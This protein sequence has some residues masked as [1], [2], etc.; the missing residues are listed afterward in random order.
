MAGEVW[1][2][3]C[4]QVNACALTG[5]AAFFAGIPGAVIVVNGQLWCYYYALRYL[6]KQD[7]AIGKRFFCSQAGSDAVVYGTED[8]LTET[9]AFI[10][11]NLQ[12]TV[13]FIENSCSIGLIGDDIAGIAG[14]AGL[15]CPVVTLDSGGLQGG[16][17]EGYRR[18]AKA[19]FEALPPARR[20]ETVPRSV[21][22][23]GCGCYYNAAGDLRELKRLLA[24]AGC[25]VLACPGAGSS[26]AEIAAMTKAEMNIVVHEELAGGIARWLRQEY[27][28][29]YLSLLPPYGVKGT[30]TWLQA[31]GEAL[32]LKET[33]LTPARAEGCRREQTARAALLEAQRIWGDLWFETTVVAGPA[34]AALGLAQA[35]RLEWLDTGF[36]TVMGHNGPA[37]YDIP[38]A[39]DVYLDGIAASGE[40]AVKLA[41]LSGGLLLGSGSE[42]NLTRQVAGLL[43]QNIAMPVYDEVLLSGQPF[44]GLRGSSYLLERL[45]NHYIGLRRRAPRGH[46]L[47]RG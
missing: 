35:A 20:E 2:T 14:Q 38:A 34:S 5:A 18:A 43:Y 42:Q 10:R 8:C 1:D 40:A 3:V 39:V 27:G 13:L 41:A 16:Y 6:E 44:M 15:S 32:W 28:M 25:Q 12:P 19:C 17:W 47:E 11:D 23:L 30:L 9:L 4:H 21:N 31:V 22:L 37:G 26:P 29:P 33:D 36:M 46:A 7:A 24:L 45:W